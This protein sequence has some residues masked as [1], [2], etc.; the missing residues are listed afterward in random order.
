MQVSETFPKQPGNCKASKWSEMLREGRKNLGSISASSRYIAPPP[1]RP[2]TPQIRFGI[3]TN[4]YPGR[5]GRRGKRIPREGDLVGNP[6]QRFYQGSRQ[7]A[8]ETLIEAEGE[9]Q[10]QFIE[11]NVRIIVEK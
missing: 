2:Y 6:V 3:I 9:S 1:S 11:K 7:G 8:V 5:R 10:G 4:R